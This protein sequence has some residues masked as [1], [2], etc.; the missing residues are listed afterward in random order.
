MAINYRNIKGFSTNS[1]ANNLTA[2]LI[3]LL[4]QNQENRRKDENENQ[5]DYNEAYNEYL[6][7]AGTGFY[8]LAEPFLNLMYKYEKQPEL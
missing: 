5:K 2:Y 7:L 3:A 1:S 6:K 4:S 8:D